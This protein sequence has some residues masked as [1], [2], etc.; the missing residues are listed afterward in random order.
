VNV[1]EEVKAAATVAVGTLLVMTSLLAMV[2][3]A[4]AM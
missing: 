2:E 4:A 1:D 3:E